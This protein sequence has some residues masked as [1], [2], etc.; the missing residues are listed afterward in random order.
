MNFKEFIIFSE[1]EVNN[2]DI[3]NMYF[4][5]KDSLRSLSRKTGKS[6]GELY[7]VIHFFGKP[8][9]RDVNKRNM[10]INLLSSGIN[11]KDVAKISGYSVRHIRNLRK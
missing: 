3:A 6:L 1:S 8:N 9:R 4:N 7:K 5:E 2:F 10:A 11:E